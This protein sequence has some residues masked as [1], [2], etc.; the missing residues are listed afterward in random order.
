[1]L[2]ASA[3]LHDPAEVREA[4]ASILEAAHKEG[5]P[6]EQVNSIRKLVLGRLADVFR[7]A[8]ANDPPAKIAPLHI[9]MEDS[10]HSMKSQS[11]H[12]FSPDERKFMEQKLRQMTGFGHIA[13]CCAAKWSSPGF[14]V[15][16]PGADMSTLL[17][18]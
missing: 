2:P 18:A 8:P 17:K 4:L 7:V 11:A 1:M 15:V 12:T 10:I 13:P 14:P 3:Q 16:K 6:P 9:E 5:L